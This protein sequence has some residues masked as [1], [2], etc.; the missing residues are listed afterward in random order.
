MNYEIVVER[1]KML[2]HCSQCRVPLQMTDYR[3]LYCPQCKAYD[4]VGQAPESILHCVEC[5]KPLRV[6][7]I[8]GSYCANC[9]YHPSMQDTFLWKIS[10]MKNPT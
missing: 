2:L 10:A 9:D 4:L 7:K 5:E 6:T 3:G 1:N 8:R